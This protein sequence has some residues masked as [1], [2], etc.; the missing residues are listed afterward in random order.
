MKQTYYIYSLISL[1]SIEHPFVPGC[2]D[3][4]DKKIELKP[5]LVPDLDSTEPRERGRQGCTPVITTE[6]HQDYKGGAVQTE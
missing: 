3:D 6:Y 1:A 2:V 4:E 5:A